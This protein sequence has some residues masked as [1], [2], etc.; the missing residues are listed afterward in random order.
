[1]TNIPDIETKLH[2]WLTE[3]DLTRDEAMNVLSRV[4][5]NLATTFHEVVLLECDDLCLDGEHPPL[6]H[7]RA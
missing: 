7:T 3:Q 1:M 5:L 2:T 4:Y 6:T